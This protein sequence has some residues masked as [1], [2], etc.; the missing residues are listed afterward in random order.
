MY[1]ISQKPLYI[2]AV[3]WPCLMNSYASCQGASTTH[4][5]ASPVRVCLLQYYGVIGVGTPP[6]N[7]TMCFDTGSASMWV[8]SKDCTTMS[9]QSHNR[10]HYGDSSSFTVSQYT[11][12]QPA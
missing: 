9:C 12:I 11:L 2:I 1:Y 5:K 4:R 7:I 10:F 3:Q 6:Q 8:P